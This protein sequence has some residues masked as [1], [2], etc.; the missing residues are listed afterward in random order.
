MHIRKSVGMGLLVLAIAVG[1]LARTLAQDKSAAT[2]NYFEGGKITAAVKKSGF[3][4]ITEAKAGSGYY[5]VM[6]AHRDKAGEVERHALDSDIFYV[7]KGDASFVTGGT[8][9]GMKA[10][11]PNEERGQSI[12][13]GQSHHLKT[14]DVITIPNGVPHWFK[15]VRGTFLYFVVKVR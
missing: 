5:T 9:V 12:T 8:A 14:G 6:M 15:E 10:T 2:V 13:G 1:W 11:A 3:T 4:T 7:V